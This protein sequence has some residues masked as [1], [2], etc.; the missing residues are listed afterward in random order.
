LQRIPLIP[1]LRSLY[2]PHIA[3][4]VHA[5]PREMA[6]QI[7]D[8]V[9]LRPEVEICYMGILNK[10]F[11]ILENKNGDESQPMA[12]PN[13]SPANNGPDEDDATE[14]EDE[15]DDDEDDEDNGPATGVAGVDL[16]E[17]DPEDSDHL[18]DSEGDDSYDSEEFQARPK[19]R[20]REILFYDDKVAIF[21]ARHGK[22]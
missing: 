17:T 19:L 12:I 18:D 22:L 21:K 8:I 5:D 11:E 2:I 10:C 6:L 1:H 16:D 13:I 14:D 9:A 3:E 7:V 4:H 15:D 20:L